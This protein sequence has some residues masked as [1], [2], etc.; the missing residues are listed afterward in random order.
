MIAFCHEKNTRERVSPVRTKLFN[1]VEAAQGRLCDGTHNEIGF[2]REVGQR[3]SGV[4][5]LLDKMAHVSQEIRQRGQSAGLIL[6]QHDLHGFAPRLLVWTGNSR[7]RWPPASPVLL[8]V[9]CDR[10][11]VLSPR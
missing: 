9:G 6:N 7:H 11:N 4:Y 8:R 2:F 5:E 3:L 1:H 10:S